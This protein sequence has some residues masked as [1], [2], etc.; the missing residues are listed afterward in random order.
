VLIASRPSDP[1]AHSRLGSLQFNRGCFPS[2]AD[3]W[4][5]ASRLAPGDPISPFNLACALFHLDR[6]EE[7]LEACRKS[8]EI[9]PTA[10]AFSTQ[11]TVLFYLGRLEECVSA[12]RK[13]TQLVPTDPVYWGE[14]GSACCW[15][16]GREAEAA[17]SLDRAIAMMRERL[18]R[19]PHAAQDWASLGCWLANRER[20]AEAVEAAERALAIQPQNNRIQAKAGMVYEQIG[21]R[22]EALRWLDEAVRN[23]HGKA[24]LI[25]EPCLASLREDPAFLAIVG[26]PARLDHQSD[27]TA[28]T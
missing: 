27:R 17:E 4:A 8:I 16:P 24:Q 26:H 3:A 19:N 18:D 5:T 25:A 12:F 10:H 7:A 23:G 9:R 2:A 22:A 21:R 6:F 15:I 20:S 28:A 1:R 14:L 11:G 13:A